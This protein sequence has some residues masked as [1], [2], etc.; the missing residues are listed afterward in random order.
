VPAAA[1]APAVETASRKA[2]V[3]NARGFIVRPFRQ[4]PGQKT[5]QFFKRPEVDRIGAKYGVKL[6][7]CDRQFDDHRTGAEP[8]NQFPSRAAT[9]VIGSCF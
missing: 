1:Y 2:R 5:N 6:V 9:V 4:T 8:R 7:V 3:S